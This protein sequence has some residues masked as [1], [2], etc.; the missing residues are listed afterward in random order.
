MAGNSRSKP[1]RGKEEQTQAGR[2]HVCSKSSIARRGG[3]S[4]RRSATGS[5]ART[6]RATNGGWTHHNFL[7]GNTWCFPCGWR[8]FAI[9]PRTGSFFQEGQH[10]AIGQV[11][12]G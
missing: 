6:P 9:S 12:E 8:G 3:K 7:L 1:V 10:S 4:C 5:Q 2:V 11:Q